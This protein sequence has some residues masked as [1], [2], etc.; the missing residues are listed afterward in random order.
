MS[1]INVRKRELG[2]TASG[3]RR[4]DREL[5]GEEESAALLSSMAPAASSKSGCLPSLRR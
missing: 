4:R 3:E 1:D 2:Q 5:E